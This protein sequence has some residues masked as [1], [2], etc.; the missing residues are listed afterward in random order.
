MKMLYS[1]PCWSCQSFSHML[2][3]SATM[4]LSGDRLVLAMP[5]ACLSASMR[6]KDPTTPVSLGSLCSEMLSLPLSEF[7]RAGGMGAYLTEGDFFWVPE[8][9][10]IAEFNMWTQ[11]IRTSVTWLAMTEFHCKPETLRYSAKSLQNMMKACCSPSQKWLES[12][13]QAGTLYDIRDIIKVKESYVD[14]FV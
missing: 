12:H 13:F 5:I 14:K 8:G 1:K 3:P 4:Q 9:C 7:K 6:S 10:L 11:G 2:A